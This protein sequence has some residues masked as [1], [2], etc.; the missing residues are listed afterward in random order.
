MK[1]RREEE[2]IIGAGPRERGDRDGRVFGS[3]A[4][5]N[6]ADEGTQ[7][8]VIRGFARVYSTTKRV[9]FPGEGR[10]FGLLPYEIIFYSRSLK[11]VSKQSLKGPCSVPWVCS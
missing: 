7:L 10:K 11:V 3:G 2:A 4:G 9:V 6:R 1:A 8:A 5:R